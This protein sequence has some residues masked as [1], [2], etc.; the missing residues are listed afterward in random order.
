MDVLNP[1]Q[2]RI[3]TRERAYPNAL[4]ERDA[5]KEIDREVFDRVRKYEQIVVASAQDHKATAR[6]R[7]KA[8]EAV[9]AQLREEIAEPLR[10]G[11]ALTPELAQ[12]YQVLAEQ[13]GRARALLSREIA[14]SEWHENR[15]RDPYQSYVDLLDAWPIL[16]PALS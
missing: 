9:L 10:N 12:R 6:E 16:R 14:A 11:A 3:A 4:A 5:I 2:V 15:C 8:A 1:H 7:V 13:A